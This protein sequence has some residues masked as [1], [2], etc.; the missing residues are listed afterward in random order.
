MIV[1]DKFFEE[2]FVM[3]NNDFGGGGWYPHDGEGK[4]MCTGP[5]CDCDERNYGYHSSSGGNPSSFWIILSYFLGLV[6]EAVIFVLLGVDAENV[7]A[8]VLVILWAV[9]SFVIGVIGSKF[10]L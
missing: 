10:G 8:L 5:G 6:C 4:G 1:I 3:G 7:P 9:L 2:V